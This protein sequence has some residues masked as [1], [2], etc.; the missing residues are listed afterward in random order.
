MKNYILWIFIVFTSISFSQQKYFIY[1][2]DK[3]VESSARLEKSS[4]VYNSALSLLSTKSIERRIK[5]LGE[6][7]FITYEDL[8]LKEDYVFQLEQI[9]IKIE[10]KLRWFNA[11]TAYLTEDEKN[12][13]ASFS[14]VEKIDTS[15]E[16]CL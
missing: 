8:P 3:G 12:K 14:F 11:V 9:G 13:V 10:N 16:V 6:D 5:N 1:F 4:P 2:K 15:K 7:N